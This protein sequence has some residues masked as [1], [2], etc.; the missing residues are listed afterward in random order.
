[1]GEL[2]YKEE[3]PSDLLRRY[4]G[5]LSVHLR[6]NFDGANLNRNL[7]AGMELIFHNYWSFLAEADLDAGLYDDRETRGNGLYRRPLSWSGEAR[8]TTDD[9][10]TVGGSLAP[11]FKHDRHGLRSFSL[12]GAVQVRP[13]SWM[14]WEVEAEAGRVR[15]E[16]A[17]VENIESG[18]STLSIFGDRDTETFDV[19]LRGTVAFT[20]DL[21]L[22]SYGQI[23]L[24]KG[25]YRGFRRLRTASEFTPVTYNGTPDF[26][27]HTLTANLVL[28]WEYLPGST[29]YFVWSQSR[30]GGDGRSQLP[31]VSRVGDIFRTPPANILL[32]KVS[33][34]WR[35]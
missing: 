29:L 28:R 13:S 27:S 25:G 11:R 24:A 33:Y 3:K 19:R 32:L 8:L 34:W 6:N 4:S 30:S 35:V 26:S 9:R 7:Q 10:Q 16:E 15:N 1:M 14:E 20:P 21:T 31:F 17:W 22:E 23:F 2:E 5:E 12:T 18:G